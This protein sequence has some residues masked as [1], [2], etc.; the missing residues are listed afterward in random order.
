[1]KRESFQQFAI[2]AAD[3]AQE[4]TERLNAELFK[5]R[6]KRPQ[7]TFEGMIA[8]ISYTEEIQIAETVS[9]DFE[10]RGISLTCLD[11]P[12]FVPAMKSDGT[13]DGR[14]KWGG[15]PH[16]EMKRTERNRR[17]CDKLFQ[18]INSGE[19]RLCLPESEEK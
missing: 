18:M 17:A 19:V 6:D 15:C 7:V 10:E 8:R 16:S 1:M 12:F 11:C 5:L 9:D 13:P 3:S 2:V 4:L 14:A